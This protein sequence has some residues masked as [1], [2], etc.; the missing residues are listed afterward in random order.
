MFRI[1]ESE[2]K[3]DS[4]NAMDTIT[5]KAKKKYS[6]QHCCKKNMTKEVTSQGTGQQNIGL[7]DK[8]PS[9]LSKKAN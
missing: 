2:I 4:K 8:I 1:A 9:F 7:C 6:L 5:G 3:L